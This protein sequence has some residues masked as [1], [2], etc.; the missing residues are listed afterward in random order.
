MPL[1]AGDMR[2]PARPPLGALRRAFAGDQE[3][4][5]LWLSKLSLSPQKRFTYYMTLVY[6]RATA[7]NAAC[8]NVRT[9]VE[10]KLLKKKRKRGRYLS[11]VF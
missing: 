10:Y 5:C 1:S 6:S 2:G 4:G 7:A 3:Y 11:I 8:I 9:A